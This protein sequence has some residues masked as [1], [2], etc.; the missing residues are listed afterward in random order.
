MVQDDP[1]ERSLK[2]LTTFLVGDASVADTLQRIIDLAVVAVPPA[3][4]TGITML[5]EDKPTTSVFSDPEV[6]EVDQTQY[7]TGQGPCLDAFRDKA[8]YTIGSTQRDTRW[9][10]F[11]R[12]AADHGIGSTLSLP[13]V[14][15]DEALGALNFYAKA[16]NAFAEDDQQR[17]QAFATQ[18]AAVLA[19]A[20]AYWDARALNEQLTEAMR[21]RATVEQAKGILMGQSRVNAGTAFDLLRK[22]SQRENRMLRDVAKDLV[23]RSGAGDSG[24]ER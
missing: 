21:S 18:A 2:A 11:S 17:G 20:Q 8:V 16:E 10:S 6:P 1:V 15:G 24:A 4:Y 13:L 3:A 5:V 9:P 19:N 22:L 7:D 14:A 23:E 12:T